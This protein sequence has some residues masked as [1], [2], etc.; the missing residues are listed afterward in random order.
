MKA[1]S[2]LIILGICLIVGFVTALF[3]SDL[4]PYQIQYEKESEDHSFIYNQDLDTIS[5]DDWQTI[6]NQK[7]IDDATT[8]CYG[9][10]YQ[11]G[12]HILLCDKLAG[13]DT[14]LDFKTWFKTEVKDFA[15]YEITIEETIK[16]IQV[17]INYGIINCP[18]DSLNKTCYGWSYATKQVTKYHTKETQLQTLKNINKWSLD[19]KRN[20]NN[21]EKRTYRIEWKDK[22][23]NMIRKIIQGTKDIGKMVY[24]KIEYFFNSL[25]I[26]PQI[27][28]TSTKNDWGGVASGTE[29][30]TSNNII[31]VETGGSPFYPDYLIDFLPIEFANRL[32][33]SE[34]TTTVINIGTSVDGAKVGNAEPSTNTGIT[35][36]RDAFYFDGIDDHVQ[37]GVSDNIG[38]DRD[39][40]G[41]VQF[42]LYPIA[43]LELDGNSKN[44]IVGID[45]M[46]II[47]NCT[48]CGDATRAGMSY[49]NPTDGSVTTSF[50]L[51]WETWQ[52]ITVKWNTTGHYLYR[53]AT[54]IYS[55]SN[56]N[57]I[58]CRTSKGN[59]IGDTLDAAREGCFKMRIQDL[60]L[61]DDP[62]TYQEIEDSYFQAG[63][64][65][66]ASIGNRTLDMYCP[67]YPDAYDWRSANFTQIDNDALN[68][69]GMTVRFSSDNST[70]L[71][72]LAYTNINNERYACAGLIP[73]ITT[74][75]TKT[76]KISQASIEF[77]SIIAPTITIESPTNTTYYVDP[78]PINISTYDVD[79]IDTL[80][81]ALNDG[82][83]TSIAYPDNTTTSLSQA[84]YKLQVY[85]N[86]T[87]GMTN[88]S[89]VYFYVNT[90]PT[91]PVIVSPA[92]QSYHTS[93][94]ALTINESYDVDTLEYYFEVSNVSGFGNVNEGSGLVAA[95]PTAISWTPTTLG[96]G[97]WYWKALSNDGI[98]NSTWSN[99]SY[100]TYDSIAPTVNV[101]YNVSDIATYSLPTTSEWNFT[102]SD[103]NQDSCY[104]NTSDNATIGLL[105]CNDA[106]YYITEWATGG[107][108]F[109]YYCSNDSAGLETC[110]NSYLTVYSISST[111]HASH[112][113]IGEGDT[114]TFN[115]FVNLTG[116]VADWP[117]TFSNLTI[118]G[119]TY[120]TNKYDDTNHIRFTKTLEVPGDWGNS[121][122]IPYNWTFNYDIKNTTTTLDSKTMTN[123]KQL[124]VYEISVDDCSTYSTM[125]INYSLYDEETKL[126]DIINQSIEVDIT[127]N[128][129]ATTIFE[130]SINNV[131]SNYV[132]ICLSNEVLN[133]TDYTLSAITRYSGDDH[134][135]EFHYFDDYVLI[136]NSLHNVNLYD[137][138]DTIARD[139]YSTSFLINYQDENYLPIEGAIVDLLRYYVGEGIYLS[140]E[141][142]KTDADGNSRLHFVTEDV[143]YKAIIRV[144]N[145][146]VYQSPEFLALCQATPCQINFQKESDITPIGDYEHIENLQYSIVLDTDTRVV[147]LTYATQNGASSKMDL[148]VTKWDSYVNDT[149]CAETQTSSGGTLTCT[150]PATYKNMTYFVDVYKDGDFVAQ[151]FFDLSPDAM[152]T[153]GNTGIILSA[154]IYLTAVLMAVSGG[155]ISVLV[156]AVIGVI[157]AS[158][159][160]LF[161]GGGVIGVGSAILWFIVA[162]VI[163]IAKISG[164][165][166]S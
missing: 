98:T 42:W 81:Y 150:V 86:D 164:R 25:K 69:A 62:L 156:F 44:I 21:G 117:E 12:K 78:I 4:S 11:E 34:T 56:A 40:K 18:K 71:K 84:S 120:P 88:T 111:Q 108:K 99:I 55:D 59:L 152:D 112:T 65:T 23:P 127:L 85:V 37:V 141:H 121:T 80:W 49:Y 110:R 157:V 163:I 142:A 161:N 63:N 100:F 144:D 13:S 145:S 75:T 137:L 15:I 92:N 116:I 106:T 64:T 24:P 20:F 123:D 50:D 159:L 29:L 72:E 48:V 101:A 43:G 47:G 118:N 31:A 115:L 22:A 32:N 35:A 109:I 131:S 28:Y 77:Y 87:S 68:Y 57:G 149:F 153:F 93:L 61:G 8:N 102:S 45:R 103:T 83:N 79:G 148:N 147:T 33:D 107:D 139:E 10:K 105:T 96:Q 51:I 17:P 97:G 41:I 9:Y 90:P 2:I 135:V 113:G 54:L 91:I 146:I 166:G 66:Y 89:T 5:N 151:R 143:K 124:T 70:I 36:G 19:T 60:Y 46:E 138:W 76:P 1:K 133:F 67:N 53:N 155:G 128:Y 16:D 73:N 6:L 162:I 158:A 130:Y 38:G 3:T 165:K 39:T 30:D 132:S 95:T 82:A 26:N 52:L 126:A 154:L 134:A 104:Y 74:D 119:T 114:A 58:E 7:T 27:N 136:N 160:A 129:G 14:E 125:I 94:P 122:G 140:V